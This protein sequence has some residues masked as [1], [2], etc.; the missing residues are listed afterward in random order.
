MHFKRDSI[1]LL[2]QGRLLR[3]TR[4]PLLNQQIAEIPPFKILALD[5]LDLPVAL[6][7]FQLLLASDCFI[8]AII[9]FDVY[10]AEHAVCLD[11]RGT[12]A[13]AMLFKP[14]LDGV[15]HADVEG[16]VASAGENV[17]VKLSDPQIGCGT[18]SAKLLEPV[19]IGPC[20]RRDDERRNGAALGL[21]ERQ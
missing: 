2:S 6:P 10:Q 7:P 16:A 17:D 14:L 11:E 15:R 18:V 12:L 13:V 21:Q 19:V 1:S 4:A 3:L 5:Q 8:G 20:F 9:G